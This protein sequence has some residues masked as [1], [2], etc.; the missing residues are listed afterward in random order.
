MNLGVIIHLEAHG[1]FMTPESPTPGDIPNCEDSGHQ[2]AF[3]R[4][5]HLLNHGRCGALHLLQQTT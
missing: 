3:L 2:G 4:L 5:P 1:V